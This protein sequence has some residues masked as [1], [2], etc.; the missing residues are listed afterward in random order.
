M[1]NGAN[2]TQSIEEELISLIEKGILN[3]KI[4][5]EARVLVA[6]ESNIRADV[7]AEAQDMVKNY[8]REARLRLLRMN[9][10]NA[11]LEVKAPSKSSKQMAMD[12]M[13]PFA[14]QQ[15][16][17][18]FQGGVSNMFPGTMGQVVGRDSRGTA[19]GKGRT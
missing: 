1:S 11:G 5:L 6:K 13:D 9:A 19:T 2:Q 10:V 8:I 16:P 14:G 12:G 17:Q 7:H 3:A 18:K 4:D 15:Q